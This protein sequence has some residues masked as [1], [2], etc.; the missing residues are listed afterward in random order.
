M[1]AVHQSGT[2]FGSKIRIMEPDRISRLYS[3]THRPTMQLPGDFR[4]CAVCGQPCTP[5]LACPGCSCFWYCSQQ[6]MKAHRDRLGHAEECNRAAAA[7]AARHVSV[8]QAA[9]CLLYLQLGV[10]IPVASSVFCSCGG[11]PVSWLQHPAAYICSCRSWRGTCS[12]GLPPRTACQRAP[13]C[14]SWACMLAARTALGFG[15]ARSMAGPLPLAG[16][17][18]RRCFASFGLATQAAAAPRRRHQRQPA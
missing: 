8:S 16:A 2:Q 10:L 6:H 9:L 4:E 17:R 18:P 12:P 1:P 7:A 13:G 14:A 15:S 3:A 11:S 5:S